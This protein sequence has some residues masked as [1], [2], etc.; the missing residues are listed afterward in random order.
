MTIQY[1][2]PLDRTFHAL[3]NPT[4]RAMLG[5]LAERRECS[6]GELGAPFDVAQATAS[7]HIQ[8]LEAAG[9]VSRS[10]R[11]REHFL[12]LEG[13]PLHQAEDWLS[14][15]LRFWNGALDELG[16]FLQRRSEDKDPPS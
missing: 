8:V 11:G 3:G 1:Q 2:E 7:K 5:L 16:T 6:A 12:R 14:R 4:R 10:V 15:H 9:L 13:G